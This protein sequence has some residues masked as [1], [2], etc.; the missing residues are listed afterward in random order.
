MIAK[1]H[2]QNH[3]FTILHHLVGSCHT[4]DAAYALLLDLREDRRAAVDAYEVQQIRDKAREIRALAKIASSDEAEQ[5]D[6]KADL[7][8]LENSRASGKILLEAALAEISTIDETIARLQPLRKYSHLPDAEA[9]EAIQAEEWRA[10]MRWRA[11]NYLLTTGTIP[12]D[13]LAAMRQHPDFAS[14]IL[15]KIV[16]V[17]NILASGDETA[18]SRLLHQISGNSLLLQSSEEKAE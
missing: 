4:A 18:K 14:S 11:E 13:E 12:A 2:R 7:M 5:L 1:L 16:E 15:P 9:V 10:E 3:D 6:G 8:E 17:Q